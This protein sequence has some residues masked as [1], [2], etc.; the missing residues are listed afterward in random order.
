VKSFS[1]GEIKKLLKTALRN[2]VIHHTRC[3]H[4]GVTNGGAKEFEAPLFHILADSIRFG[5]TGGNFMVMVDNGFSTGHKAV[6]VF[7]KRAK[8][9]L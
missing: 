5:C 7:I 3:L 8:F 6:Q 1:I 9:L 2:M 4:M